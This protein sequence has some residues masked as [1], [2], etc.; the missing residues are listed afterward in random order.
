MSVHQFPKPHNDNRE[1]R[2][3]IKAGG[4]IACTALIIAAAIY[5]LRWPLI[6][7]FAIY[8]A[9]KVFSS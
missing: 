9:V 1:L 4:W 7:L 2:T 6:A 5:V 8:A 3:S